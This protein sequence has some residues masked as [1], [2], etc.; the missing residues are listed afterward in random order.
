[1]PTRTLGAAS[2]C[3]ATPMSG[4]GKRGNSNIVAVARTDC[5]AALKNGEYPALRCSCNWRKA[6]RS[7]KRWGPLS[8]QFND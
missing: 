3:S 1:M 8:A 6:E 5:R 2:E 4:R 7:V